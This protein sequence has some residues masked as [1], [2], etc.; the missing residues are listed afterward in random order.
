MRNFLA[1]CPSSFT[2]PVEP[3]R[4]GPSSFAY[5][6]SLSHPVR[7][8]TSAQS[9]Q[10]RS[11]VAVVSLVTSMTGTLVV[12]PTIA[13]DTA[14][15]TGIPI[16][17]SPILAVFSITR[18]PSFCLEIL[19][20]FRR[21]GARSPAAL[22]RRTP[23]REARFAAHITFSTGG[24]AING[25]FEALHVFRRLAGTSGAH[26]GPVRRPVGNEAYTR[27]PDLEAQPLVP[28]N[29]TRG[30]G[31][32]VARLACLVGEGEDRLQE[33]RADAEPLRRRV[34]ADYLQVPVRLGGMP[35]GYAGRVPQEPERQPR[36][37]GQQAHH[38]R[39]GANL[40]RGR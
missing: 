39:Q 23:R 13:P 40:P 6:R 8:G 38:A 12:V 22:P 35:P 24:R 2:S 36:C 19:S 31:L 21:E 14:T 17:T 20:Q 5:S 25:P 32:Q 15:A 11:L 16:T 10:T 28:D 18:G 33:P 1:S 4:N 9:S 27:L 34:D 26:H 30:H 7:F 3:V 29:V 37:G